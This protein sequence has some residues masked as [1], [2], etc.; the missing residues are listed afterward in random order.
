[1]LKS[2]VTVRRI[3]LFFGIHQSKMVF[4]ATAVEL[5][6]KFRESSSI[7]HEKVCTVSAIIFISMMTLR[8]A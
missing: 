3:S 2:A 1:L 8:I 6:S 4:L 5:L 7:V